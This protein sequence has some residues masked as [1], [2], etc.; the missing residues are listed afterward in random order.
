M[1]D[2]GSILASELQ[3]MIKAREVYLATLKQ[4]NDEYKASRGNA[5]GAVAAPKAAVTPSK[6]DFNF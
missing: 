4:R 1:D 6:G 3:E 2:E 5:L